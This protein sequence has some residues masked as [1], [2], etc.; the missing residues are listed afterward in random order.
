VPK[1]SLLAVLGVAGSIAAL[2]LPCSVAAD[3]PPL[4]VGFVSTFSGFMTEEGQADD[5]AI[6]AFIKEHGDSVSGRKL[7]IIKRDDAGNGPDVAKRLAQELIVNDHVDFLMGQI[8]TPNARAVGDVSTSSKVPD[9]YLNGG[10]GMLEGRPYTARFGFAQG[11]LLY[12]LAQWARKNGIK[13]VALIYL[14]FSSGHD[15]ATSFKDAFTAGGGTISGDIAVPMNTTDFSAY[16]Q[17]I[18]DAKPQ[19]V[20]MFLTT[21]SPQFLKQWRS[22]MGPKSGIQ[23]LGTTETDELELPILGDDAVG[24]ISAS[25][26]SAA[27]DSKLNKQFTK[28]MLA[29]D[30]HI[31]SPD[32]LSVAVYDALQAIY[33]VTAA[34]NG[35]LEPDK[36]MA[37]VRQ[38]KFESPRGPVEIDPQTRDI[39]QNIYIRRVDKVNGTYQNT[40]IATYPHVK[41]PFEK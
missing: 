6:A 13:N 24:V 8:F 38:L 32:F 16:I 11:Q 26:Y 2:V 12:P 36:T 15:A 37:L 40:E 39:I 19:A 33:K 29:A 25:N 21:Q 35:A 1:P 31:P 20:F 14:D 34:Q 9:F 27:H 5:A 4:K 17:R 23:L 22:T 3:S 28:D 30:S 7:E 41:D 10:Y 18:R